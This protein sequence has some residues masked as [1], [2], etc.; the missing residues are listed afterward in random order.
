MIFKL[1]G[2]RHVEAYWLSNYR[3]HWRPRK[4]GDPSFLWVYWG[5]FVI[6]WSVKR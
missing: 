6:G 2:K 5:R 3:W 1:R 4:K